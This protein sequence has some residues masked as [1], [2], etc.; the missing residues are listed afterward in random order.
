AGQG[1]GVDF[2]VIIDPEKANSPNSPGT[3]YWGGA[4]GTWF[5]VEPVED[6]FWL[7]M[8][9]AQGET[10]PGAADM[11]GIAADIIYESLVN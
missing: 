3:Y 10:R 11:R 1:F 9:Q 7:G 5:W 6:M 2:A 8:I 4:A